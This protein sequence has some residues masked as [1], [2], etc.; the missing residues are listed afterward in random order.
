MRIA[1]LGFGKMG[2]EIGAVAREQGDTI[3]KVFEI[4]NPVKPDQLAD[5]DICIDFSIPESVLPNIR[6]S[7]EAR[8]DIVVGTTGWDKHLPE[9]RN[10]VA[11]SGLL[12]SANFSL[13][14]NLR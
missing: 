11:E 6:A 1:L 12:Y 14:M 7:A 9:V 2:Q 8:R 10:L 4:D 3:A 5:V 13:G